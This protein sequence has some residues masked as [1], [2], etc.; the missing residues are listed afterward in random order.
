[1]AS[2]A[3]HTF[4]QARETG[5]MKLFR[6]HRQDYDDGMQLRDFVYVKDAASATCHFIDHSAES[7]LYNIGTGKARAF[8]DLS[9]AVMKGMGL[10]PNI[11]YVDMPQDL[12]GKY[13]YF[14][15]A[16]AGKLQQAGYTVPFM[17]LEDGV[18]DYVANYLNRDDPYC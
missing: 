2:V 5:R 1:M 10:Q 13:Q 9:S 11:E 6:S 12:R 15:Q 7:G 18:A 4:N 17:E 14:T 8:K 3:Y 16:N